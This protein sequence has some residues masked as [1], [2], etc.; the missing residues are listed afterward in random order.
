LEGDLHGSTG[1]G[2]LDLD[3]Y[4]ADECRVGI[5]CDLLNEFVYGEPEAE[6]VRGRSLQFTVNSF[7]GGEK[8]GESLHRDRRGHRVHRKEKRRA[9]TGVWP[10]SGHPLHFAVAE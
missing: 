1:K 3:R 7:G 5:V 6:G 2:R 9:R 4:T 10:V 8:Q